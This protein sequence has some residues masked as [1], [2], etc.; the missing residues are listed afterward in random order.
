M[1]AARANF[2]LILLILSSCPLYCSQKNLKRIVL[3][4]PAH[5]LR[6]GIASSTERLA[7][8]LQQ[9]GHAVKI[10]SYSL[11][12][13]SLLFPGKTQYAEG[14]PPHGLEIIPAINS[15]NPIN[16]WKTGRRLRREAPDLIIARFWLPFM[17]PA[18]GTILRL[19]KGKGLAKAIAIADNAVP[20]EK[21]PG[22]WLLTRYFIQAVDAFIVMS[23]AVGD[24]IRRFSPEKPVIYIPHPVFDNYG[25]LSSREESLAKLGLSGDYPY[26]LFFGFIR[27]YKGLDLLLRAMGDERIKALGLRLLVAGEFYGS[28]EPYRQIIEE[29]G[30]GDRVIL[31][32]EYVPNE[33]V[34]YYFGAAS[35]VVQ[36]YRSATQ[37]GIS[38]LAYHFE[39]PMVVTN[40]GGLPE[41]VEH[42]K[43]GYV[44]EVDAR[45][46][47]GA[48]VDY[49]SESREEELRAGM[50][51]GKLRF[52][53]SNMVK[54]IE[55]LY[56]KL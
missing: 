24:D 49:F 12:Y 56:Q 55:A 23:R 20:H 8:E 38:Q 3:L 4:S 18:L 41:I 40:V 25:P 39:V 50:R 9:Q 43:E 37:S 45:A 54:G 53:W 36:P 35:L 28:D 22:D 1:I 51:E 30:I 52:S 26:L 16:W 29:Q 32:S 19:A 13:P 46:I 15:I 44:V 14:P 5:P 27:E 7:R 11:Q 34:R 6:G 21:R 31:R 42:G 10:Y 2:L 17:G 48:I 47:A 33:E